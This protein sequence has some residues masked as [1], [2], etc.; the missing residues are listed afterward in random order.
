MGDIIKDAGKPQP[1]PTP[2]GKPMLEEFLIDP[3]YHNMNHGSFGT[4]PRHVK[5]ALR[6]YQDKHEARPDTFIRYDTPGLLKESRQAAADLI[7]APL[8]TV[9]FVPNAT[10]GVNTV[11]RNLAW[12]PDGA[13]EIL[14]F[15]T[16]YGGCGKTIDY[17]VDTRLGL[18]S[19]RVVPLTYPMEDDEI[20]SRFRDTVSQS[21]AEGKRP[22]ICIFD[23]V[24]SL[25]GVRFPFEAVAAACR[26]LGVMSLIDGA[27]GIGMI[28]LDLSAVDPDFFVSNCHKWLHVPRPCAVFYVPERNQHLMASTVP[29]S[30][31]YVPRSGRTYRNPLPPSGES[32]FVESF[33]FVGSLD[34][35]PNMTVKDAIEWRQSIG[36]EDKIVD[37]LWTLARVGGKKAADILGTYV[38][39]NKAGTLTKCAMVNVALPM[40]MDADAEAPSTAPDGTVTVPE[41]EAYEI[42]AWMDRIL[43]KEYQTFLALFW[44]AGRWY[45]RVSAQVYLDETDFEWVG[46]TMKELCQRVAK[47]EYKATVE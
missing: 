46:V 27:Q 35:S 29:T 25:P 11:F 31:G 3:A 24:S 36:G 10:V 20:V 12:S 47:Q 4:F 21:R 40:V 1:S 26:E 34:N 5:N 7:N 14:C 42:V 9:V 28:P 30:H 44:H 16:I 17:I 13:D 2:F 23:T 22:K 33:G 41:K 38:L 43:T 39:D 18:V 45:M 8:S 6:S 19:S 32:H 37:Y 15:S